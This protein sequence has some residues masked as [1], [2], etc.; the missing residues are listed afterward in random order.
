MLFRFIFSYD[1]NSGKGELKLEC[2][3]LSVL[4][5]RMRAYV[6]LFLKVKWV[7]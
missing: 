7:S 2:M 1:V 5:C 3:S 4:S 6:F